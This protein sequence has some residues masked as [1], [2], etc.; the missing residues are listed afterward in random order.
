M[1]LSEGVKLLYLHFIEKIHLAEA[2]EKED[3]TKQTNKQTKTKQNKTKQNPQAQS[4]DCYT[5]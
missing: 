2:G 4:E 5:S 3:K 1:L